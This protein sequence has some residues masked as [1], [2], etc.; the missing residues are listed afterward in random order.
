MSEVKRTPE[1]ARKWTGA[2]QDLLPHVMEIIADRNNEAWFL[3]ADQHDAFTQGFSTGEIVEA[4]RLSAI[5][6][7]EREQE[8]SHREAYRALLDSWD[9]AARPPDDI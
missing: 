8:A 4:M 2:P 3:F 1:W 6:S 5:R 9:E 7:I